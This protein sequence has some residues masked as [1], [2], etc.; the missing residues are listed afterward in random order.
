MSVES[1]AQVE[2]D[3]GFGPLDA[4]VLKGVRL[5][6]QKLLKLRQQA[7]KDEKCVSQYRDLLSK[8]IAQARAQ[9]PP[10]DDEALAA[11]SRA[12]WQW[13]DSLCREQGIAERE[14]SRGRPHME[15]MEK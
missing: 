4:E 3:L 8:G 9:L 5:I 1:V 6:W 10:D 13:Y 15:W 7:L 14:V 2:H 11:Q 12:F